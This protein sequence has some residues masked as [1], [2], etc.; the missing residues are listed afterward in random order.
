MEDG[1]EFLLVGDS[2]GEGGVAE[3]LPLQVVRCGK[4][5]LGGGPEKSVG[6]AVAI[7]RRVVAAGDELCAR[8]GECGDSLMKLL[9]APG[10][11]KRLR[12]AFVEGFCDLVKER[13]GLRFIF[14]GLEGEDEVRAG[15]ELPRA[16]K[17]AVD[18]FLG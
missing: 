3:Y 13:F 1:L 12:G 11:E 14:G 7:S 17:D 10:G 16:G 4:E 8:A 9:A 5:L 18:Q 15:A 2:D 6:I